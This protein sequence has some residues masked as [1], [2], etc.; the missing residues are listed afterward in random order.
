MLTYVCADWAYL[1]SD[2]QGFLKLRDRIEAWAR[3]GRKEVKPLEH[4]QRDLGVSFLI[5]SDHD[6]DGLGYELMQSTG[7]C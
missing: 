4:L 3:L 2:L 7:Y 5:L 6:L 1:T